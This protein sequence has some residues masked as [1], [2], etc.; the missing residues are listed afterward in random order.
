MQT[1]ED[2]LLLPDWYKLDLKNKEGTFFNYPVM[3]EEQYNFRLDQIKI[4]NYHFSPTFNIDDN[5]HIQYHWP[6]YLEKWITPRLLDILHLPL[7]LEFG[8]CYC[9]KFFDGYNKK[10]PKAY[11]INPSK[12]KIR[13]MFGNCKVIE[14]FQNKSVFNMSF[15]EKQKKVKPQ[16]RCIGW[17]PLN[18]YKNIIDYRITNIFK[19]H[20]K[21]YSF[22]NYLKDLQYIT[23][24]DF[25]LDNNFQQYDQLET[26]F[27]TV[28]KLDED[29]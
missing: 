7:I 24:W 6:F 23:L 18:F 2:F 19:I 12:N 16:H 22:D 13:P 15:L 8:N 25:L 3:T 29:D 11:V 28:E 14:H 5:Y 27:R 17:R 26:F 1:E 9:C 4:I 21:I 20:E 10:T